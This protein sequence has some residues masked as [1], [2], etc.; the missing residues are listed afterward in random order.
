[1]PCTRHAHATHTHAHARHKP[2]GR[3]SSAWPTLT[4]A[5]TLT[6]TLTKA[7]V[8]HVEAIVA[9]YTSV[10][11]GEAVC[12]GL[13]TT[14]LRPPKSSPLSAHIDSGSL[15][16]LYVGCRQMLRARTPT[17]Q[18][19]AARHGCQSLVHWAG[20]PSA[21]QKQDACT[22]GLAGLTV[23]RF[24]AYLSLFHPDHLHGVDASTSTTASASTSASTSASACALHGKPQYWDTYWHSHSPLG[25][26]VP[27]EHAARASGFYEN[28]LLTRRYWRETLEQEGMAR[29]ELPSAIG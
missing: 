10:W 26:W 28:L 29:L 15:L 24:F 8:S 17:A 21:P 1:M 16:E 22:Y 13:P 19:W 11:G 25:Q 12:E 27:P 2:G 7:A 14:I 6:L 20:P 9:A 18:A 4:L 5:L 23:S 3:A